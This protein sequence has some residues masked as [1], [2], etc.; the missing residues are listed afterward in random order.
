LALCLLFAA[1]FASTQGVQQSTG[2]GI[3]QLVIGYVENL[4]QANA[5]EQEIVNELEQICA[6]LGEGLAQQCNQMVEQYTPQMIQWILEGETPTAFCTQVGLCSSKVN[7]FER[8]QKGEKHH[9]RKEHERKVQQKEHHHHHK[10]DVQQGGC[11][12]CELVVQYIEGYLQNNQTEQ[13]IIQQLDQICA[14]LGPLASECD[15]FVAQ[16]TPQVIQWIL[17]GNSPQAFCTSIGLCSSDKPKVH[18][19]IERKEHHHQHKRDVQQGGCTVCELVMQY[20]EGFIATNQSEAQII[21]QL[22]Q[23]CALLGPLA[24]ECD[25]FVALY[26]PQAIQWVLANENPQQFCTQVGLCSSRQRLHKPVE[27]KIVLKS[28]SSCSICETLVAVVENYL[29]SP[30]T[31]NGIEQELAQLCS[32]LPAPFND[33]CSKLV[34]AYLPQLIQWVINTENPAALC[35]QLSLC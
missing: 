3:C 6:L 29:A 32:Q 12:V 23:I 26:V 28:G 24:S 15:A 16:Y 27:K 11:S 2:C 14:L 19:Q 17:N 35:A 18:T 25:S 9:G 34:A 31:E 22:D 21:E 10:R 4:L 20:V 30:G 33:E 13:Q 5:T 1:A 8:T 7:L